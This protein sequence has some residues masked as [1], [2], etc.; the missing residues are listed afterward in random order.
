M[1]LYDTQQV[2]SNSRDRVP[3]PSLCTVPVHSTGLDRYPLHC[4]VPSRIVMVR[5]KVDARG[6]Y[7][8]DW[9]THAE[10]RVCTARARGGRCS[11]VSP[12]SVCVCWPEQ[13]WQAVDRLEAKAAKKK[14]DSVT[15]AV[16]KQRGGPSIS[17]GPR[18]APVIPAV[19]P[20]LTQAG[21]P[22]RDAVSLPVPYP[23]PYPSRVPY[24]YRVQQIRL[25][26]LPDRTR[27]RN[28]YWMWAD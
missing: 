23:S 27:N 15:K 13:L 12:C 10:C 21:S 6:H 18:T 28:P 4:T 20:V 17:R 5:G 22:L 3:Y 8:A 24:C 19:G 1:C 2:R 9:D 25:R 26:Y 16:A 14:S 11:R 7:M